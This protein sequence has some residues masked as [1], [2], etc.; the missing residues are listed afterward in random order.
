MQE[1]VDR[2]EALRQTCEGGPSGAI[3]TMVK[4]IGC[5]AYGKT[6][7][8]VPAWRVV[9]SADKPHDQATPYNP[10]EPGYERYWLVPAGKDLAEDG[11]HPRANPNAAIAALAANMCANDLLEWDRIAGFVGRIRPSYVYV[12]GRW[13]LAGE[14][15][16]VPRAHLRLGAPK[17]PPAKGFRHDGNADDVASQVGM[18]EDELLDWFRDHPRRPRPADYLEAATEAVRRSLRAARPEPER[19]RYHRP[20]LSAFI[21]ASVRLKVFTAMEGAA[22]YFVKAD[23]DSVAFTRPVT[24]LDLHKSRYGAWKLEHDGDE[25]IVVGKKVYAIYSDKG[26]SFVCKALRTDRLTPADYR[27]WALDGTAPVQEQVQFQG[28]GHGLGERAAQYAIR[29]RAGTRFV[30]NPSVLRREAARERRRQEATQ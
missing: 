12:R 6:A 20:Q 13:K 1:M 19:R 8:T 9:I 28:L 15:V 2:L 7:E 17:G 18:T 24:H 29:R 26:W 14:Y 16:D 4:A 25:A 11:E 30:E 3:G 10:L 21:T 5:N 23:T 22:E 27:R